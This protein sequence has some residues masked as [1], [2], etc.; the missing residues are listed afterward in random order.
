MRPRYLTRFDPQ[1]IRVAAG[2][3][4]YQKLDTSLFP[5]AEVWIRRDDLLDPLISGNKAYKLVYNLQAAE[6]RG[7]E[8]LLTCGGAWSN[9]I[10]ATAAAARRFGYRSLGII[11]GYRP[12]AM[13]AMLQDAERMGMELR[14]ISRA[15]YRDRDLPDFLE[16][17][18]LGGI[19]GYFI[20]EGGANRQGVQGAR[21]LGEVI[22]E[23][24]PVP[25]EQVWIA[26]GTGLTLAGL[27]A[28][29]GD[30]NAV[31]IPVLRAENAIAQAAAG[32]LN[33]L[34]SD[35]PARILP[36]YHCG[37]YARST[38]ELVAFQ[39]QFEAE[40]G[41]PLDPVYTAKL[42]YA[43]HRHLFSDAPPGPGRILLVHSGGLQGRR[44]QR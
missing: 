5:G 33:T 22:R 6:R 1:Y 7:T 36:G 10:H 15:E 19:N 2:D 16:R 24:A 18:G 37:G 21:L 9:H 3:I 29:L 35:S 39:R 31:G 13:S 41:V 38:R 43:L 40:T 26:C 4:P 44:G 28:G 32:W 12:K 23:T 17:V 25:F 20:P 27:Q 30:L 14:F 8:T 11:R 42:A 34:R